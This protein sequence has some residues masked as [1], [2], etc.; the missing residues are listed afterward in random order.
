MA[1]VDD[2]V[3]YIDGRAVELEGRLDDLDRP[4]HSGAETSGLCQQNLHRL[5]LSSISPIEVN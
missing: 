4:V 1:I 5:L 2:F 3:S